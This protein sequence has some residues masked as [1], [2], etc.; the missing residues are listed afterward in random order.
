MYLLAC[1]FIFFAVA[2]GQ[3]YQISQLQAQLARCECPTSNGEDNM[4]I[5]VYEE[6][7]KLKH[8]LKYLNNA[9]TYSTGGKV[10]FVAWDESTASH[11]LGIFTMQWLGRLDSEQEEAII[12]MKNSMQSMRIVLSHSLSRTLS[13]INRQCC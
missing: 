4:V 9:S 1:F 3:N 13:R 5:P 8:I 6:P 2:V 10:T 11:D 7:G 12:H